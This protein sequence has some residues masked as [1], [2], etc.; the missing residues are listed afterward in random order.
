[1]LLWLPSFRL[2]FSSR[3][4]SHIRRKENRPRAQSRETHAGPRRPLNVA[5]AAARFMGVNLEP[6]A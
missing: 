5:V 4:Q 6:V 3:L 1:M 2:R